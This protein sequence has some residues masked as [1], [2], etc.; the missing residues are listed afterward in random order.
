MKSLFSPLWYR[1]S[2][3]RPRLRPHAELHRQQ[4]RGQVW[5]VLQDHQ[6]G[7]FHRISPAANLMLNLM[8]GQRTVQEL[9]DIAGS[10]AGDD[11]PTQDEAIQLL[12]QLHA[13]DLLQ[14]EIPPDIAELADRSSRTSRQELLQRL[15]NPL[16]IRFPL[17]DPDR[18]LDLT[19][20]YV[21]PLFTTAGFLVWLAL[22]VTAC[23]IIAL[24]WQELSTNLADRI[25]A[26]E[27]VL[28][29]LCI[30]PLLKAFHELGHAYATKV[31]GGEVHEI[32]VMVLVLIPIPYVD[33]SA[34]SAFSNKRRRIVVGAAGI[35]VEL[36]FASIAAIIWI[37]ASPG[38]L[39]TIAFN[40]ML[41]GGVSTI[42]FNGNPLLRFDGYYILS[43]LLEIPNLGSRANRYVFYLIQRY[44]YRIDSAESP[45][46]GPG[47]EKWLF[48]YATA[49]FFYR[50]LVSLGIAMLLATRLF[51][52]GV[53]MALWTLI[54]LALLPLIKGLR[55]VVRDVRL[56]G[57]RQHGYVVTGTFAA[58]IALLLFGIPIPYASVAQGVVWVPENAEV[59]AQTDGFVERLAARPDQSVVPTQALIELENPLLGSRVTVREAQ[60]QE[61]QERYQTAK[62]VDR[63]QAEIILEQIRHIESTLELYRTIKAGLTV[64]SDRSGRLVVPRSTDLPGRYVKK[65]DLLGYVIDDRDVV[66]RVVVTQDDVDLVRQRTKS[67]SIRFI[68]DIQHEFPARIR[69]EVPGGGQEIPSLALS[70]QG[71]GAI[72]LN[73]AKT[74]KPEAL[75]NIFQFDVEPTQPRA[76]AFAGSRVYVRFDHGN[77]P[78]AW[79]M[80]R[81]VK[82]TFLSHFHV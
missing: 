21:R 55:F 64:A 30:Y 5:Y 34:A 31:W 46:T 11:P 12:A 48:G 40:V 8:N 36:L 26:A 78:I 27:N 45:V 39:R 20:P 82:Q 79:R 2:G 69:R 62:L 50:I 18:I 19:L 3:L 13:A 56:S 42:I 81:A 75:Y 53:A 44:I 80:L 35:L 72:A 1:V 24:H 68:E 67:V 6:T 16:A 38:L 66:V 74:Q 59:R 32:G 54:S 65:G 51:I 4:F 73:P 41:I 76:V 57:R 17:F 22:L 25:L 49:S 23:V 7:R 71:G 15:R 63:V 70:T 14:A 43:D 52:F 29:I 33:A 60:L 9:W 47:E 58:L 28:I 37:N 77:E 61:M 10:R